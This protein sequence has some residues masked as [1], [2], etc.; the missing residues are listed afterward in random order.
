[1]NKTISVAVRNKIA[2]QTNDVYY[3]CGNSDY[4][5]VFDFDDEWGEFVNKTARF[6]HGDEYTDVVFSGNQCPVPIIS[7]T[8]TI[9]VGVYA[10]NLR[11]TTSAYIPAR[12]S[13]LCGSATPAAP[14]DD[15]YNQIMDMFKG[16]IPAELLKKAAEE[17]VEKNFA[18]LT[19]A[20]LGD[21][22]TWNG[23]EDG[24]ETGSFEAYFLVHELTDEDVAA[25]RENPELLKQAKGIDQDGTERLFTE[26]AGENDEAFEYGGAAIIVTLEDNYDENNMGRFVFPKKGIYFFKGS[27]HNSLEDFSRSVKTVSFTVPGYNFKGKRMKQIALPRLTVKNGDNRIILTSPKG[28]YWAITV[29]DYGNLSAKRHLANNL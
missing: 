28:M 4:V 23:E 19:V 17:Y 11:T 22:I 16:I 27:M 18:S 14:S 2:A 21:T 3:I 12:K 15:V 5:V 10:G 24:Y 13:V 25:F 8:Y 1:M 20:N 6:I 9:R 7:D 29:D 26:T